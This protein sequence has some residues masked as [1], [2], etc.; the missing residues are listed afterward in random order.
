L[1]KVSDYIFRRLADWGVRH[2]FLLTGGGAMHLNDSLGRESR[3]RYVCNHHEQACA[4]AAESYARITGNLGVINVTTGPGGINALNGVFGA[5]TDSIP[6]LV[7]SGQVK[8]ETCLAATSSPDLRQLGDQEVDIV[9]IASPITKYAQIVLDP[10]SIRYHLERAVYLATHGRPGPCWLDI[11]VDVQAARVDEASLEAY[12]PSEDAI[13]FDPQAL[14]DHC[15]EVL[16][17][18]RSAERP[19]IMVGTGVRIA[20]AVDLFHSV[21]ERLGIPVTTAFNAHDL[22]ASDHPLHCGRPATIGDRPGNLAV[23]N[24][25]VLLIL[26]CRLN[27]RQVS[28]N[29]KAF[30][31]AA[32]KIQVD[33][34][35]A[36]LQKPTVKPDLPIQAD[37]HDFLQELENQLSGY[38][39]AHSSWLDWCRERIKLYPVVQPHHRDPTRPLNPYHFVDQLFDALDENDI[40][41]C[42][43]ATACVVTFQAGRLK[44]GQRLFSNSGS[45]SMGYD[46]PAAIGAA[47]ANKGQRVICMAGDGSVQLNIQELQTIVHHNLPIKIFVMNNGGY[48]SIRTTQQSFFAGNF[49]GEGPR[50]G[51]SFPDIV[52]LAQAYGIPATR[53]DAVDCRESIAQ[54]LAAPGPHLCD[55][56]LDPDQ[57]FE[58]RLSSRVLPDGK[59]VSSPLEDLY[60]F[61]DREELARNLLIPQYQGE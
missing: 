48:L 19:V 8:R 3:I 59:M 7:L 34:D 15:R 40:V 43:D 11:P 46:L 42:G 5:W 24:S 21:I 29:W 20:K 37:L 10:Q 55:V 32:F 61:L 18:I 9:R 35:P 60:P 25:D 53:I 23:Q 56:V 31:R 27:I 4:M 22:L 39:P 2:V 28:Y 16:T 54:I 44:N 36:E 1:V 6:M 41:A 50:S 52:R 17:R 30:A 33:I 49:V 57:G 51:V 13:I 12:H 45:A 26:G 38:V 58:P 14:R 47:F